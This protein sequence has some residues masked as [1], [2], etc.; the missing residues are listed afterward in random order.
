M[1][2]L[3][4]V[5]LAQL[6]TERSGVAAKQAAVG[7][8]AGQVGVQALQLRLPIPQLGLHCA[9]AD[10][11]TQAFGPRLERA[12]LG[13]QLRRL[14]VVQLLV[15][16]LQVVEEDAPG[17]AV[18]DQMMDHQQQTLAAVGQAHQH[19][20]QQR[21]VAEVEAALRCI[22]H[23]EHRLCIGDAALPQQCRAIGQRRVNG[24]PAVIHLGKA[25]AQG[26]VV[27]DQRY[28]GAMQGVCM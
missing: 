10:M 9:A 27:F 23:I 25:Q 2:Q 21:P 7:V 17:H 14:T 13:H 15:D 1:Q 19:R 11:F 4:G 18:D 5:G 12:G 28:Q 16:L 6:H 24:L 3:A 26:I 22:A 8:V 20:A